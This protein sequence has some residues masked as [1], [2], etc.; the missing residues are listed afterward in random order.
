MKEKIYK[1]KN[2]PLKDLEKH[3]DVKLTNE[4]FKVI[5][6][7]AFSDNDAVVGDDYRFYPF[8][9]YTY[10]IKQWGT[11]QGKLRKNPKYPDLFLTYG[12]ENINRLSTFNRKNTQEIYVSIQDEIDN[13]YSHLEKKRET[14]R[15]LNKQSLKENKKSYSYG[16]GPDPDLI[17]GFVILIFLTWLIFGVIFDIGTD[18]GPPRFFGDDGG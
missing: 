12:K 8:D 18:L 3:F 5:K 13:R 6:D 10:S 7:F 17:I 14:I 15:E 16:G 2:M 4:E 11:K 1:T 9:K